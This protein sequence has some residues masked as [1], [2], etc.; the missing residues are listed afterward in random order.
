M[1]AAAGT[2]DLADPNLLKKIDALFACNVGHY[3]HLPQLVVVGNQSSGKS[4]VLEGIS[5]LPFPKDSGLCTQFATQIIF[6]RY[7]YKQTIVKI[8]PASN[9]TE[10]HKDRCNKWT[11]TWDET[12]PKAFAQ[13][14]TEV[15]DLSPCIHESH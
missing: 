4:S 2:L 14:L 12:D 7:N 9:A 10:K 11:M 13:I 15:R 8:I 6:R 3:I 1:V 5:K